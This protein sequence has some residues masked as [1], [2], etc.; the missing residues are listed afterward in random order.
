LKKA[1]EGGRR[2][3]NEKAKAKR[4]TDQNARGVCRRPKERSP[5]KRKPKG[6]K[7]DI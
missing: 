4:Q 6:R 7:G 1:D 5:E 3:R 2:R